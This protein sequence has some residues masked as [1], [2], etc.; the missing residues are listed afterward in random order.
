MRQHLDI[1]P[2]SLMVRIFSILPRPIARGLGISLAHLIRLLHRRLWQVGMR[3]LELAFPEKPI[4]ERKKLCAASTHHSATSHR[5]HKFRS[6][7][8]RILRRSP[9]T[10]D[11]SFEQGANSAKA[12][13][14]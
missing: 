13:S 11:Q 14:L 2:V 10:K 12:C 3:N 1:A 6:T 4:N 8:K 9:S 5:V 7:Q